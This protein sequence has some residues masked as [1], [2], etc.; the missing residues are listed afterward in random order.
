MIAA[1]LPSSSGAA[2]NHPFDGCAD[3]GPP[4]P[5]VEALDDQYSVGQEKTLEIEAPGVLANDTFPGGST[6]KAAL[7][8][9]RPTGRRRSRH[10]IVHLSPEP[11]F[12]GTDVSTYRFQA[13]GATSN[14]ARVTITV[15]K[16]KPTLL[17]LVARVCPSYSDVTANLARNDIQESLADLGADTRYDPGQPIDPTVEHTYQPNCRPLPRWRFTLGTGYQTR[18]G[19]R[20]DGARSRS[21]P[22]P[23]RRLRDGGRAS[24]LLNDQG[25]ATGR[26]DPG[27]RHRP[28]DRR[29]GGPRRNADSPGSRAAL[30]SDPVLFGPYPGEYGF[31]ALRCA[32]DNLNGDNVEWIGYPAG[33]SHVFCYAYYVKPPPTSGTHPVVRKGGLRPARRRRQTFPFEGN[34]TFN[35]DGRFSLDVENGAPA[36]TTFYRAATG[37]TIRR[38]RSPRTSRR[39][40]T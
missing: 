7:V 8:A 3:I 26:I 23:T 31:A 6:P 20:V 40:G 22:A 27:R 4:P 9:N 24:P 17:T 11:K 16:G 19:L 30:P 36:E 35:A 2:R 28:A 14:T 12:V 18:S 13:G 15:E 32:V 25:E 38:G 33:A 29:A 10:R 37:P 34:V 39:A 1:S 21:S 5:T